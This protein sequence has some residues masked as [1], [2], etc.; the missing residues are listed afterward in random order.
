M[1]LLQ[2]SPRPPGRRRGAQCAPAATAQEQIGRRRPRPR[3]RSI[4]AGDLIFFD[5]GIDHASASTP[6]A[7][8]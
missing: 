6:A 3:S 8:W 2:P 4:H 1:R 7:A 5:G